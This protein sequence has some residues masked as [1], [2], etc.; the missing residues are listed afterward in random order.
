MKIYRVQFVDL[1]T[2][3]ATEDGGNE[4]SLS[5]LVEGGPSLVIAQP[6]V[7]LDTETASHV[8]GPDQ[9]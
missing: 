1:A 7:V 9:S 4:G 5:W 6:W 2:M 8:T 3:Q